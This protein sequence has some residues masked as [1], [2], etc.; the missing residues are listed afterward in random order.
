MVK[1]NRLF[2]KHNQLFEKHNRL[3]QKDNEQF[4][5]INRLL[6]PEQPPY[7]HNTVS[8]EPFA[9]VRT[10]A[11]HRVNSKSLWLL[12]YYRAQTAEFRM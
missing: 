5:I 11:R 7:D 9:T 8:Q 10:G 6:V 12:G 3:F 2:Q 4:Q 1:H